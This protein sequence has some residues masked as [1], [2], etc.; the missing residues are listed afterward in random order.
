MTDIQKLKALA[1]AAQQWS[2][3]I[4]ETRW[5]EAECFKQ[6]YFSKPDAEFIAAANPASVLELIAEIERLSERMKIV[7]FVHGPKAEMHWNQLKAENKRLKTEAECAVAKQNHAEMIGDGF[8]HASENLKAEN[9][10]L[11][12]DAARLDW[13]QKSYDGV[14]G[15]EN[16]A[17]D[18]IDAA[19]SKESSH[20]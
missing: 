9:E 12:K 17:R 15:C 4:G 18:Q 6:P 7:D 3:E 20:G 2:G 13:L 11:R 16:M 10:A 19:M 8:H 1:E 14:P 5:Y